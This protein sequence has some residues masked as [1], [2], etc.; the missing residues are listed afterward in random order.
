[1]RNSE[2]KDAGGAH[3]PKGR[4]RGQEG[5][6]EPSGAVQETGNESPKDLEQVNGA[7]SSILDRSLY[8]QG[9]KKV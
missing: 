6:V 8:Q 3:G 5:E 9:G 1:M 4:A 2:A 7:I